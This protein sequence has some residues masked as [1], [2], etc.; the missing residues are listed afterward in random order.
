M[1]FKVEKRTSA[2]VD[3]YIFFALHRISNGKWNIYGRD[4]LFC[5]AFP[6]SAALGFKFFSNAALRAKSLPTPYVVEQ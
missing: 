2:G 6:I 5:F 1:D 3:D 4:N